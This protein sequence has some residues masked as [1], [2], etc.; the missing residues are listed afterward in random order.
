MVY[1]PVQTDDP[2]TFH[3][4]SRMGSPAM[5]AMIDNYDSFTYNLVQYLAELGHAPTVMRN[6]QVTLAELKALP[7]RALIISPG[8]GA[9]HESGIS[10]AAIAHF[11]A[12][13]V[14][15]FGVCLGH[16][17]IGE[18]YGGKI[19]HAPSLMHGKV[20]AI[21]HDGSGVFAN[22]P[23]GFSATRYHSLVIDPA[24]CPAVLRVTAKTDDS[25][26]MGV[27]HRELPV[28]GVQFHPESILTA[29]G[30]R[31]LANFLALAGF[32]LPAKLPTGPLDK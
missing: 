24:S 6:D 27:Q 17:C 21:R 13:Q 31:L 5:I 23:D 22:I 8:P 1:S 11:A 10:C 4:S 3:E 19:V 29:H 18:V 26:I 9:P 28:H 14:P 30:H 2:L 15:T 16:Q 20:S 12:A 25:V 32:P 7:I